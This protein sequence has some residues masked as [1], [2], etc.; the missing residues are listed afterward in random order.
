MAEIPQS[1]RNVPADFLFKENWYT[2]LK[3]VAAPTA[4]DEEE[5]TTNDEIVPSV[6]EEDMDTILTQKLLVLRNMK[7]AGEKKS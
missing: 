4:G 3:T 7:S 1:V 5:K 2:L 6:S